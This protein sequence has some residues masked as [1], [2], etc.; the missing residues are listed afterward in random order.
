M[1]KLEDTVAND[2]IEIVVGRADIAS[3][4][5]VPAKY[6]CVLVC[7]SDFTILSMRIPKAMG[8]MMDTLI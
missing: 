6:V 2:W 4:V 1:E 3:R 8:R 7:Y 5:C